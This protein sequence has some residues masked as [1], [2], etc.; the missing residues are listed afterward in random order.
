MTIGKT[1][2]ALMAVAPLSVA[3]GG[4]GDESREAATDNPALA[5]RLDRSTELPVIGRIAWRGP[6]P[7]ARGPA[8]VMFHGI[9]GG[10]SHRIVL[11]DA[12]E[13]DRR[14]YRVWLMDLPGVGASAKPQRRYDIEVLDA[15][16]AGFLRNVVAQPAHAVCYGLTCASVFAVAGR[17]PDRVLSVSAIYP[18]GVTT[19]AS[20]PSLQAEAAFERLF[21]S[22]DVT[23]WNRLLDPANVRRVY[24]GREPGDE[25]RIEQIVQ[26]QLLQRPN[27]DQRWISLSFIFGRIWRP[28]RE[29]T[30][31][32]RQPVLLIGAREP[33]NFDFGGGGANS[34]QSETV[35]AFREI[36]PGWTY[37]ERPGSNREIGRYFSADDALAI[38]RFI[39]RLP[40]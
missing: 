29:A 35:A 3:A 28:F 24:I 16:V 26:R 13:L 37:V 25:A 21:T 38:D 34:R 33:D 8:V 2:L 11:P 18:T 36:R 39:A 6:L 19:Y 27:V 12:D 20:P 14:G 40:R 9:Y 1:L 10:A 7:G 5:S 30:S 23:F 32:V 15:F 31:S 4:A 17:E 22:G